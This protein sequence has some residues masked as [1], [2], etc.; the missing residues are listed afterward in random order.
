MAQRDAKPEQS[1]DAAHDGVRYRLVP[2]LSR[3]SPPQEIDNGL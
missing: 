3:C 1:L 2:P